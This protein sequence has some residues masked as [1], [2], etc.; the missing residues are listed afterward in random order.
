MK[1][2]LKR[3]RIRIF[4]GIFFGLCVYG[5]YLSKKTQETK[6]IVTQ[7]VAAQQAEIQ[8]LVVENKEAKKEKTEAKEIAAAVVRKVADSTAVVLQ[9]K[10]EVIDSLTKK[11]PNEIVIADPDDPAT[12]A[13]NLTNYKP[14]TVRLENGAPIY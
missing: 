7:G 2:W 14:D 6:E 8:Q 10:Q 13:G 5:F 3:N 4:L 12:I 11:I 9:K 1:N